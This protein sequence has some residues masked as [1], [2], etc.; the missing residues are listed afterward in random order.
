M[1]N[2]ILNKYP[3]KSFRINKK[4]IFVSNLKGKIEVS[5]LD[6]CRLLVNR[7]G[8]M[9]PHRATPSMSLWSICLLLELFPFCDLGQYRA[10]D[11][12]IPYLPQL[13]LI[14]SK[15]YQMTA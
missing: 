3:R 15:R 7:C 2:L 4:S 11:Y 9:A 6:R 10:S 5:K 12:L 14:L 8:V 13:K 1:V